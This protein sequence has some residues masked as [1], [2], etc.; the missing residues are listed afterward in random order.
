MEMRMRKEARSQQIQKSIVIKAREFLKGLLMYRK[1][2]WILYISLFC[3]SFI[4]C[5]LLVGHL[6][7]RYRRNIYSDAVAL[8]VTNH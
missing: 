3:N 5:S 4:R 7:Y 8:F 1:A 6:L 2:I